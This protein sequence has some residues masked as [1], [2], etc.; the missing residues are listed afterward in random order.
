MPDRPQPAAERV[1][2]D[3]P[4]SE[5]GQL[6]EFLGGSATSFTGMLLTLIAKADPQNMMRLELAFPRQVA[7]W[8]TWMAMASPTPAQLRDELARRYWSPDG[9]QAAEQ[10]QVIMKAL[11]H[12]HASRILTE[13]EVTATA[14][15]A[16]RL[17]ATADLQELLGEVDDA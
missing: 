12:A 14:A 3:I 4:I 9:P 8:H 10:D 17:G 5:P 15:F 7:A 13:A 2:D 1:W 6:A 16:Y 11:H